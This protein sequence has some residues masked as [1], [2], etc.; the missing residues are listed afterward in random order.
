VSLAHHGV[1][2]LDEL[3]EFR[4]ATLEVLRQPLEEGFVAVARHRGT[5]RLP[6]QFQLVAAMNPCPCGRHG[7]P[8]GCHCTPTEIRN[9]LSRLSG[10]LLD[11]IDL[12]VTLPPLAFDEITGPPGDASGVVR[13]RVLAARERQRFR[14]PATGAPC[15]ARL[16]PSATRLVAGTSTAC[17]N[18]LRRA[19]ERAGLTA[20]GVDRLLRVARTIADLAGRDAVDVDDMAEAL[21]F[22]RCATDTA[23][24]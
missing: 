6:A 9:Y 10:P 1:L 20:R 17:R 11:R 22:R 21:Q 4:R 5:V 12:H 13:G 14:Q 3:A 24:P 7:S 16:S 15:N 19:V 2:F 18:L 8:A 23:E